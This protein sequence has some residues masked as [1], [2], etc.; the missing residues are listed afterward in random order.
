MEYTI[1]QG[2]KY[3]RKNAKGL[4]ILETNCIAIPTIWNWRDPIPLKG[5]IAFKFVMYSIWIYEIY[6]YFVY[7]L[8]CHS[9]INFFR[10]NCV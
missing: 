2:A 8:V 5:G 1:V 7:N 6:S 4:K 10:G 9:L 3:T